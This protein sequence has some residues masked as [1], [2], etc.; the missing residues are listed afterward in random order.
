[1]REQGLSPYC[2]T[3]DFEN[4][5]VDGNNVYIDGDPY[6]ALAE[7]F[8][9]HKR[10]DIIDIELKSFFNFHSLYYKIP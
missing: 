3:S 1:M 4:A 10:G 9:A 8:T 2:V 7:I 6:E 5:I